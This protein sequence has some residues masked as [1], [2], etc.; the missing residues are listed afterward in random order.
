MVF[1]MTPNLAPNNKNKKGEIIS[2]HVCIIQFF[3]TK[4]THLQANE[5]QVIS[6]IQYCVLKIPCLVIFVSSNR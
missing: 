6:N 3:N 5:A 2:C 1:F 4:S